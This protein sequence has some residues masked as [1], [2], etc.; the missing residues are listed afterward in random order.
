MGLGVSGVLAFVRGLELRSCGFRREIR[1]VH[2]QTLGG[3][4]Q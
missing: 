2:A 4:L 3:F 1:R